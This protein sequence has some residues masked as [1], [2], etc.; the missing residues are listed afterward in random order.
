MCQGMDASM[1]YDY[2]RICGI[3]WFAEV[4]ADWIKHSF[5]TKVR[6]KTI[7]HST[8]DMILPLFLPKHSFTLLLSRSLTQF[9][10]FLPWY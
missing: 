1:F 2:M 5:I 7:D 4:L 6:T 8:N 9:I 10:F 3:I